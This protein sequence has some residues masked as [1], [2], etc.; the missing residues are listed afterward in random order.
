MDVIAPSGGTQ[1]TSASGRIFDH[2]EMK[3][4]KG[5]R[6]RKVSFF[7]YKNQKLKI[8]DLL[9]ITNQKIIEIKEKN[10]MQ[11]NSMQRNMMFS[12]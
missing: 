2:F 5:F 3:D 4:K 7:Y 6:K 10:A 9:N 1:I 11:F 12:F 8:G